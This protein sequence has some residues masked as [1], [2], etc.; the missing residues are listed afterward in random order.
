[1]PIGFLL[2]LI[3]HCQPQFPELNTHTRHKRKTPRRAIVAISLRKHVAALN[4]NVSTAVDCAHTNANAAKQRE[5]VIQ[6][7][8]VIAGKH[9]VG[10]KEIVVVTPQRFA[11]KQILTNI[12]SHFKRTLLDAIT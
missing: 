8:V 6:H 9:N 2:E 11:Q 3:A 7:M 1:M 10:G 4:F 5:F 12:Q